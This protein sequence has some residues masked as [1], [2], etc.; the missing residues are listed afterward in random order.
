[1]IPTVVAGSRFPV[2]SS[3]SRI[4]GRLTKARRDRDPLLLAAGE[5][6]REP[7]RLLGEADEVEHLG[8]LG[9]DHVARAGR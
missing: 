8:H 5:L 9:A 2:G 6:G 7:A 4:S 3:A 1:M